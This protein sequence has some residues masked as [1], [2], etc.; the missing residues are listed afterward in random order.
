MAMRYT[1]I[2]DIS[3]YPVLYNCMSARIIYLHLV[4]KAGWGERN[5]DYVRG[6]IRSLQGELHMTFAATR[7]GLNVLRKMGMIKPAPRGWII[8]KYCQPTQP[9]QRP[10]AKRESAVEA[11][12]R[13][14]R[15][16]AAAAA[17]EREAADKRRE[18]DY[19]ANKREYLAHQDEIQDKLKNGGYGNI[20]RIL[21][22]GKH[23]D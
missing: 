6:S 9:G 18:A 12:R 13:Q 23:D 15:A 2:I 19:E 21:N 22:D 20:S 8:R 17:A 4:L 10:A 7:H 5:L 11:K 14:D 3:E 16:A 1:T